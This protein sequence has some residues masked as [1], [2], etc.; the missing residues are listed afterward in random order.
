MLVWEIL[1][2]NNVLLDFFYE[3]DE[4]QEPAQKAQIPNKEQEHVQHHKQ[5]MKDYFIEGCTYEKKDFS[6]CFRLDKPI[7]LWILNDLTDQ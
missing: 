6:C 7:F 2:D 4:P 3:S 5:L 1:E